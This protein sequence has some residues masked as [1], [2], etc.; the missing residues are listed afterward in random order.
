MKSNNIEPTS[1]VSEIS[2]QQSYPLSPLL[3]P[4]PFDSSQSSA[5]DY[6]LESEQPSLLFKSP[7]PPPSVLGK[8]ARNEVGDGPTHTRR[9]SA[10][11]LKLQAPSGSPAHHVQSLQAHRNLSSASVVCLKCGEVFSR[12]DSLRRHL[13]KAC[14]KAGI[15]SSVRNV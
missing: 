11:I 12:K 15:G 9:R 4:A 7:S 13:K 2:S 10:R 3:V 1:P 14:A 6:D 8:H 5:S